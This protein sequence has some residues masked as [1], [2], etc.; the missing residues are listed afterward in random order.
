[1]ADDH[2]QVSALSLAYFTTSTT[3]RVADCMLNRSLPSGG[4]YGTKMVRSCA[5][6]SFSELPGYSRATVYLLQHYDNMCM[7]E[8][9]FFKAKSEISAAG[10][11]V[12]SHDLKEL[13][14]LYGSIPGGQTNSVA[15]FVIH[16]ETVTIA[17]KPKHA[18]L[19]V[20]NWFNK[21]FSRKTSST[22]RL[23]CEGYRWSDSWILRA[24]G[25]RAKPKIL[26]FLRLQQTSEVVLNSDSKIA[27]KKQVVK[28]FSNFKSIQPIHSMYLWS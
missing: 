14:W 16:C 5:F 20:F 24:F 22:I 11:F 3:R 10:V 8:N 2:G 21:W 25:R 23:R 19:T 6:V 28:V 18:S 7:L 17:D 13:M 27:R 1:M 4:G 26:N 9:K 12:G 15:N